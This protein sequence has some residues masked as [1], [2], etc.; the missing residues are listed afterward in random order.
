MLFLDFIKFISLAVLLSSY[1]EGACQPGWIHFKTSCYYF[2][3][4]SL[5]WQKAS[6][7]CKGRSAKLVSVDTS[8]ENGFIAEEVARVG[9]S[10]WF[11]GTDHDTEGRWIWAS[12]KELFDFT[13]WLPHEPSNFENN[14]DCLMTQKG[15]HG[16]WNDYACYHTIQFICEH[17]SNDPPVG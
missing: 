5:N 4:N 17:A 11:D 13:A 2:S 12:S 15:Y 8:Q 1:V 3:T 14:E 16:Q 9:G 10:F 7:D 6:T